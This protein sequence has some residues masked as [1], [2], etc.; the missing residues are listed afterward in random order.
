MIDAGRG[1]EALEHIEWQYRNAERTGLA[2]VR[3]VADVDTLGITLARGP[4][5]PVAR[6]TGRGGGGVPGSPVPTFSDRVA[7]LLL[8]KEMS[9]GRRGS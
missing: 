3:V 8:A 4:A 9:R 5:P 1:D 6:G 2:R 7:G